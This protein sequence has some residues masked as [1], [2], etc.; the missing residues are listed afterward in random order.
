VKDYGLLILLLLL[1]LPAVYRREKAGD[2]LTALHVMLVILVLDTGLFPQGGTSTGIFV[3]PFNNRTTG[4][5]FRLIPLLL[6]TRW[7]SGTARLRFTSVGLAWLAFFGWY[8]ATFAHGYLGGN[9]H[10]AAVQEAKMIVL[11]GGA[12]LLV[13]GT[14]ARDLVGRHGIPKVVR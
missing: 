1:I 11:L 12:A 13:A 2:R 9:D 14:P 6:V 10:H 5:L 8:V 7:L 4:L 3:L